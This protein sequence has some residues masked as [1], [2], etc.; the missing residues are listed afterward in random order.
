MAVIP[1]RKDKGMKRTRF[2]ATAIFFLMC[3]TAALSA[4]THVVFKSKRNAF[5]REKVQKWESWACAGKQYRK[6]PLGIFIVRDDL[7]LMWKLNS[8]LKTYSETPIVP[9]SRPV[10]EAVKPA[11]KKEKED[12]RFAGMDDEQTFEWKISEAEASETRH[13]LECRRHR[14]VGDA[15]YTHIEMVVWVFPRG[16][17]KG[18]D[19]VPE[20]LGL[21]K[22]FFDADTALAGL[23]A[24][25]PEGGIADLQ[26]TLETSFGSDMMFSVGIESMEES[27]A[28]AGTY[29]L[30]GDFKKGE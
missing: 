25:Y 9:A 20:I 5:G 24:K 7:G 18:L 28:P 22:Q 10:K 1:I 6:G 23:L 14:L 30:P 11:V 29:E 16:K 12:L 2:I 4:D 19:F 13:G 17:E 8:G 26:A 27:A 15:D 3:G 21:F